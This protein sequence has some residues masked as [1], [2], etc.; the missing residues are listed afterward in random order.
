MACSHPKIGELKPCHNV[1]IL[2]LIAGPH[3]VTV[4]QQQVAI[5]GT[6]ELKLT[7]MTLINPATG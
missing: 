6:T 2:D 4:K 7:S 1:H 5:T 3:T